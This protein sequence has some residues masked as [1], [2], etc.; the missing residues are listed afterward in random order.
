MNKQTV[1]WVL[2]LAVGLHSAFAGDTESTNA[3]MGVASNTAAAATSATNTQ[4]KVE[5][6]CIVRYDTQFC[7]GKLTMQFSPTPAN[8]SLRA[9]GMSPSCPYVAIVRE[10]SHPE[11]LKVGAAYFCKEQGKYEFLKNVDLS[12]TDKQLEE[13]FLVSSNE[14]NTPSQK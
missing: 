3:P 2:F 8:D 10:S 7:R 6:V 1:L 9:G 13:E 4:V 12:L 14:T 11:D 5:T